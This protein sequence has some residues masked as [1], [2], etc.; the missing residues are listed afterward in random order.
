MS[1]TISGCQSVMESLKRYNDFLVQ[2]N[3]RIKAR[4]EKLERV[5]EAAERY[6]SMAVMEGY[7]EDLRIELRNALNEAA[8][9]GE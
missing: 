9:S 5:R 4:N 2:E 7:A 1:E 6:V 8:R 3:A